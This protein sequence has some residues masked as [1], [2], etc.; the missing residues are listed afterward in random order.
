MVTAA[1]ARPGA[2]DAAK[3]LATLPKAHLHVHLEGAMRPA[4]L[5]ELA[6][7]YGIAVPQIRGFGNFS[8]FAGMYVAACD[9]L[10]TYDDLARVVRE[11]VEDNV[12]DGAVWVEPSLYAPHHRARLG[13][14]EDVLA[15]VIEAGQAAAA[16]HGIG[17]GVMFA[18]DRTVDAEQAVELARVAARWA[19]RG[20]VSFG[21]ANDEELV[22]PEPFAVAYRIAKDAGLLSTPHAGEL[23]GPE[24]VIGALDLLGADRLQHGVRAFEDPELVER[25]AD[26]DVCLDV[27]PSS[28]LLLSV[29]PS[30]EEH[31]LPRLLAAGVNCSLN[32]DDPLLFGPN[33]LDEY[34][35]SRATL[36]LDDTALA[37]VARSSIR[38]SGAP[39]ELKQDALA[40]IDAWERG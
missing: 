21:L 3:D 11:V 6:D 20:V 30:L 38:Y 19:G 25:L 23:R 14:D 4:T 24:S 37:Q 36:G 12:R 1:P 35:L 16:E 18:A 28:N 9:V 34:R 10:R 15:C 13:P 32:G 27:C 39:A 29:V 33:L 17:F 2:G 31:P 26:S 22:G 7:R 8:A 40:R 5:T